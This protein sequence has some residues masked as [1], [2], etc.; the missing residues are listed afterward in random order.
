MLVILEWRDKLLSSAPVRRGLA[1]DDF[2]LTREGRVS[3]NRLRAAGPRVPALY[4]EVD[5]RRDRHDFQAAVP[6]GS[7]HNGGA[8][9]AGKPADPPPGRNVG[10]GTHSGGS[11]K[12]W[13]VSPDSLADEVW[14]VVPCPPPSPRTDFEHLCLLWSRW[15][16]QSPLP[17]GHPVHPPPARPCNQFNIDILRCACVLPA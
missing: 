13:V 1:P 10:G 16:S 6:S 7:A 8:T 2:I 5:G 11:A 9:A 14:R 3:R 4:I 15:V 17:V 12:A